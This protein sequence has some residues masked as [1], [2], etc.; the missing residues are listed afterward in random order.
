MKALTLSF[1]NLALEN[2]LLARSSLRWTLPAGA[3]CTAGQVLAYCNISFVNKIQGAGHLFKEEARDLQLAMLAPIGGRVWP[4]SGMAL[5]GWRESHVQERW[6]DEPFATVESDELATHDHRPAP[7]V[8]VA[9]RRLTEAAEVRSGLLTG[10]HDR[11]RASYVGEEPVGTLMAAGICDIERGLRGPGHA[12]VE[13][14]HSAPAPIQ[15]ISLTDTCLVP[16]APVLFDQLL[17]T[18]SIMETI[19]ADMTQS[20]L[21]GPVSPTSIDLMFCGALLRTMSHSPLTEPVTT[22]TRHGLHTSAGPDALL[23]SL[24]AEE[25]RLL[26]HR[27]LGYTLAFHNYRLRDAGEASRQWLRNHFD[28][29][30]RST[31][32]V[33][34]DYIRL[35][36]A[37]RSLRPGMKVMIYNGLSTLGGDD[38]QTYVGQIQPLENALPS[39]LFRSRNLMLLELARSDG[40]GVV[41]IDA[42]AAD[43][44]AMEHLPDGLHGDGTF[45]AAVRAEVLA[46]AARMGIRGFRAPSGRLAA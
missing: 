37:L 41:D 22:M 3:T 12:F 18:P 8:L 45:N 28:V 10:W 11:A 17:R 9:G 46:T 14:V 24:R 44:G 27:R 35:L 4:R 13:F 33:R 40:I 21:S 5:G 2:H 20:L 29:I 43:L 30:H 32:Q 39:V 42:I 1:G 25:S 16:A 38:L 19:T 7:L 15:L 36:D 34:D 6:V 26:R 23:L 31:T